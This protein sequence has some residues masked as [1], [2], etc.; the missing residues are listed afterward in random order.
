MVLPNIWQFLEIGG[1]CL[2]CP[3]SKNPTIWGLYRGHCLLQIGCKLWALRFSSWSRNSR[4]ILPAARAS[5]EAHRFCSTISIHMY[6]FLRYTYTLYECV[7]VHIIIYV[8][9]RMLYYKNPRVFAHMVMQGLYD[10]Q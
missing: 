7:Y 6:I 4:L 9:T 3:Y 8:Y 1:P 5:V 2:G 10:Q